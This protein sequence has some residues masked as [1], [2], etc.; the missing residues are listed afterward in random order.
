MEPKTV[1]VTIDLLNALIQYLAT[2]P[3]HEVFQLVHAVQ[4]QASAV[5]AQTPTVETE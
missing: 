2:R 1:P 5:D 3:Y 4:Q